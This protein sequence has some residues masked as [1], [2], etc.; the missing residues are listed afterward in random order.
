MMQAATCTRENS[1]RISR[2]VAAR[3]GMPAA[4]VFVGFFKAGNSVGE[5]VGWSDDGQT[6]IGYAMEAVV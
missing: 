6:A 3:F 1:R 2:T 5:G 4:E